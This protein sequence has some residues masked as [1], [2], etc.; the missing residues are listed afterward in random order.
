MEKYGSTA[1]G[2]FPIAASGSEG[3]RYKVVINDEGQYSLWRASHKNP[4]GWLDVGKS[5]TRDECLDYIEEAWTDIR[6]LSLK[7]KG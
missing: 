4:H 3:R 6:P 7:N 5:G 2:A 1:T